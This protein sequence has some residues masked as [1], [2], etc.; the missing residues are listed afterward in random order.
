LQYCN[1]GHDMPNGHDEHKSHYT[2]CLHSPND[3][4]ERK[5]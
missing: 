3:K 4:D 5:R 1:N 2:L